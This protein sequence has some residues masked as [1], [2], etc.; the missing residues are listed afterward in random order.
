M[1]ILILR[2]NLAEGIGVVER[3]VGAA[4]KLPALRNIHLK[5]SE[6]GLVATATNLEFAVQAVLSGKI[7]EHGECS[8]PAAVLVPIVR[9]L[10]AD[11]VTI[12]SSNKVLTVVTDNYEAQIPGGDPKDFPLVP[13]VSADATVIT[14]NV[15]T[16]RKALGS[17]VSSAQ[18]SEIRPEISGVFVSARDGKLFWVATDSFRLA[19]YIVRAGEFE[20]TMDASAIIPLRT[21]EEVMRVFTDDEEQLSISI[22]DHQTLFSTP[23][24]RLMSRL[25]DG[26]YPEYRAIIPNEVGTEVFVARQELIAATKLVSA[27]AGRANDIVVSIGDGGKHLELSSGEGSL[28]ANRYRIPAKVRGDAFTAVFNWKFLFEGLRIYGGAEVVLGVKSGG[29]T[30][31]TSASEPFVRYVVMP[32]RS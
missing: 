11:R 13:G 15:G 19:E 23:T 6:S 12:E 2:D 22:D 7:L 26:V 18:Y 21:A 8:I 20:S 32:I 29:P 1:K 9:N 14:M 16:A 31:I 25:V 3:A 5:T 30:L 27:L 4:D 24:R 10:T 28:G 17:V